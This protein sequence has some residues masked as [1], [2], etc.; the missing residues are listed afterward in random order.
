MIKKILKILT[1]IDILGWGGGLKVPTTSTLLSNVQEAYSRYTKGIEQQQ[2][3]TKNIDVMNGKRA[4]DVQ[5]EQSEEKENEL[6]NE[7]KTLQEE[8]TKATKCWRKG[9]Q[10]L[11]QL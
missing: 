4:S 9:A 8:L 5:H 11:L 10:N 3:L 1:K 6:I 7:Q 2:K